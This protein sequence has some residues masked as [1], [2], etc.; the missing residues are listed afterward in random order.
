MPALDQLTGVTLPGLR[1]V[2]QVFRAVAIHEDLAG[3]HAQLARG[4]YLE[5]F[6]DRAAVHGAENHRGRRAVAQQLVQVELRDAARVC[7]LRERGLGRV[8]VVLQ[9]LEQRTAAGGDDV[10]L[11]IVD[12]RVDEAR[13][14]DVVTVADDLGVPGQ[15]G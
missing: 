11:G 5:E 12:V 13:D 7:R 14:E 3:D 15:P 8:R 10:G 9:P 4:C 1:R 2:A 6:L